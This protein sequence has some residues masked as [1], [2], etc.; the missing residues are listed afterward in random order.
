MNPPALRSLQLTYLGRLPSHADSIQG[1]HNP[2]LL[3][4][5]DEWMSRTMVRLSDAPRWRRVYDD[6]A[7][8]HFVCLGARSR[9]AIAGHLRPSRNASAQRYPFLVA[10]PI[11]VANA[12]DFMVGAPML[13][14]SWW[15]RA[16]RGVDALSGRADVDLK[17][18][19]AASSQIE[20]GFEGSVEQAAYQ[21]FLHHTS[22][23]SLEQ[24]LNFDGHDVALKGL[25]LALGLLLHPV[26]KNAEPCFDK[27]LSLP[28]PCD[29]LLQ[30]L[31]ATFSL[32]A[33]SRFFLKS[34]VELLLCS[35]P[36]DGMPRLV[37]GFNGLSTT[38]LLSVLH[39]GVGA[40]LNITIDR[41]GWVEDNA[42]GN[43]AMR[44][45]ASRLDRSQ[46]PLEGVLSAFHEA[47][48]DP[49]RPGRGK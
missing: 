26:M 10:V 17:G 22:L 45:L 30:P 18:L 48:I 4:A 47:F 38:T 16:A 37:V 32:D 15:M 41:P 23:T 29:P 34:D 27:G 7:P 3:P 14:Q 13:L 36:V 12:S 8:L 49:Q 9:L 1:A 5:L 21:Q 19:E 33:V 40:E 35:A 42:H 39:T 24:M 11:E 31:V 43:A 28:L 2:Q 20:S 44:E 25:M 46:Q 6:A